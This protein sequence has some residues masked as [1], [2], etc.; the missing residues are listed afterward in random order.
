[1]ENYYI[2]KKYFSLLQKKMKCKEILTIGDHYVGKTFVKN[3]TE[4]KAFQLDF[5][6]VKDFKQLYKNHLFLMDM[7]TFKSLKHFFNEEKIV[8]VSN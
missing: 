8:I 7:N 4:I 3:Q 6:K 1:M 2:S 5:L